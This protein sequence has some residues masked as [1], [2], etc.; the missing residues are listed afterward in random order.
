MCSM[1]VEKA[2]QTFHMRVSIHDA[3]QG[4]QSFAKTMSPKKKYPS[5][6]Y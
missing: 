2:K 3:K 5:L 6:R 1:R 4:E